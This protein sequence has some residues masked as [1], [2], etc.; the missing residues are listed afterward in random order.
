MEGLNK[1]QHDEYATAFAIL[2]L[3]DGGVSTSTVCG[4]LPRLDTKTTSSCLLGGRRPGTRE[5]TPLRI[6]R[7]ID[8]L[9][10]KLSLQDRSDDDVMLTFCFVFLLIC[11]PM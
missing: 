3:Y 1:S 4:R 2:A 11:R 10:A 6:A 8:G 7:T 9:R 5:T